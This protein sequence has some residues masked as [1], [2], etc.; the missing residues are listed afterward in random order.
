MKPRLTVLVAAGGSVELGVPGNQDLLEVAIR[1]IQQ[2]PAEV[3]NECPVPLRTV[4]DQLL[5]RCKDYYGNG[6]NF[7]HLLHVLE[8][9]ATLQNSLQRHAPSIEKAV[10]PML[11]GDPHRDIACALDPYFPASAQQA[12]ILGLHAKMSEASAAARAHGSWSR[13]QSFWRALDAEFD[14]CVATLNYD[15]L[16]AQALNAGGQDQGFEQIPGEATWRF[17]E[18]MLVENPRLMHLHG[19]IHFGDREYGSDPNRFAYEDERSDLYWHPTAEAAGAP[20]KVAATRSGQAE[21]LNVKGPLITGLD[22][23]DKLLTEPYGSY[24]RVFAQGLGGCNRLLII[25]YG[26]GDAHINALIGRMG[27]FHGAR[28]RIAL[29]TRAHPCELRFRT[30]EET[31]LLHMWAEDSRWLNQLRYRN[32]LTSQTGLA[33]VYYKG[34]SDVANSHFGPLVDFLM[35]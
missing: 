13:Y 28:R 15:S 24:L 12:L 31:R 27:R 29:V 3:S 35:S 4:V 6:Y 18:R 2:S 21:R 14:L 19:S 9:L 17:N 22:K 30:T 32:P 34:L 11:V 7:E 25:G 16:I 5:R 1:A 20:L 26:F 23:S 10:E 8:A 33:Q